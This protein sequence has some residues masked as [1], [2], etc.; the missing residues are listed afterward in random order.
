MALST[1]EKALLN[2]QGR[3][4]RQLALADLLDVPY[5]IYKAGNFTTVGGDATE[6]ISLS[7][8]TSSDLAIVLL[9]TA[10]ATPRTIV[11]SAAGTDAVSVVMSGDP[12]TDH[13]LTYLVLRAVS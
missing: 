2:K 12:S 11:S 8:V 4:V 13:V 3:Y 1:G 9:K 5:K 7:G 10:G 6:S